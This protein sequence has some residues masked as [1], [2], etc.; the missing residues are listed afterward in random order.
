MKKLLGKYIGG[1]ALNSLFRQRSSVPFS[2]ATGGPDRA[3]VQKLRSSF[4]PTSAGFVQP[5]LSSDAVPF[6]FVLLLEPECAL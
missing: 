6:L 2:S 4:M 5:G 1:E 3:Y